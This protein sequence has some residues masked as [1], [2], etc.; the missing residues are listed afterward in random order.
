MALIE[1]L[2][3]VQILE[4]FL[5]FY[6]TRK[7]ITMLK[8]PSTG[9]YPEPDESSPYHSIIISLKYILILPSHL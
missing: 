7:F 9:P 1:N 5:I 3:V 8:D 6:V 4:I 2:P